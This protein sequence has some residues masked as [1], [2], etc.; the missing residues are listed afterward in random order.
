[1]TNKYLEKIAREA[2][3]QD[4]VGVVPTALGAAALYSSAPQ[5]LGYHKLYHGTSSESAKRI[6]KEGFDPGKG[7]SGAARGN[8]KFERNSS[9]KVH[10]TKRPT[11][12]RF[13]ASFAEQGLS[14]G[15]EGRDEAMSKAVK[16][17][18]K[19][20]GRVLTARVPESY[21]SAMKV[22]PD[23]GNAKDAAATFHRKVEPKYVSR[24]GGVGS[25]LPHLSPKHLLKYYK[26]N[27]RRALAGLGKAGLGSALVGSQLAKLNDE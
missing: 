14:T 7:G 26:A 6:L 5:L 1:M 24:A 10:F 20:K 4:G 3:K 12:S 11:V 21:W 15:G 19:L 16:G 27:P 9:G 17:M 18:A 22:D 23:L 13:F 8:R 2:T 25:V